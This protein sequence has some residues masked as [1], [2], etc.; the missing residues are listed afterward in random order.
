MEADGK[1]ETARPKRLAAVGQVPNLPRQVACL[2]MQPINADDPRQP[3]VQI[4]ASIRAAILTGELAPGS[5]LPSGQELAKFF[6]VSRMTVQTAIRTLQAEGFVRSRAGSG[7]YVR[8]Q[9]TLPGPAEGEHPLAGVAT[10]LFEM[11]HLKQLPRS[12]WLLL[13]VP[14]PETVAEHSFRV[15][16]VGITL[17]GMD[18]ADVGR[19]A[20]LCLMHD[21]HET[22]IGDV[23][24]VGRAYVRTDVPEAV[25]AQQTSE[26]PGNVAKVFQ[27]LTAEYEAGETL[28]SRLAHDADKIETL[29]QA[30]E[31]QDHG[32][33]AAA[34]RETS[35]AALRTDSGRQ[36]AQAV[37]STDPHWWAAFAASY[38]EL[39]ASTRAHKTDGPGKRAGNGKP[40]E[41]AS[42]P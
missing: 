4:A 16:V 25:T 15:A 31:Y 13:G 10:F 34:W 38:H 27:D 35:L 23:P 22:R 24:S 28:E 17:A 19:T 33:D 7:V 5:Q 42:A 41:S 36:L 12:G 6:G 8:D 3:N 14:Q 18:G 30:I 37:G 29:L 39:R 21:A 2:R 40:P 9:A 1:S 32:H 11:G 26:M 20:A